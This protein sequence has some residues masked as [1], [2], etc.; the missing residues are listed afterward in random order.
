MGPRRQVLRGLAQLDQL[1]QLI[2]HHSCGIAETIS[3]PAL[4][5]AMKRRDVVDVFPDFIVVNP[6]RDGSKNGER[7]ECIEHSD[8]SASQLTI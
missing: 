4:G 8:R 3:V 5:I 1:T 7:T 2:P 6:K